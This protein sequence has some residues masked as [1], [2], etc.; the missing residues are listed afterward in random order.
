MA[1]EST[2][3][4]TNLGTLQKP[5]SCGK[6]NWKFGQLTINDKHKTSQTTISGATMIPLSLPPCD[7]WG[8][9]LHCSPSDLA[10][11]SSPARPRG[12]LKMIE[13]SRLHLS[14]IQWISSP[15]LKILDWQIGPG[16]IHQNPLV[17]GPG[18]SQLRQP[19]AKTRSQEPAC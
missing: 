16:K 10:S 7:P 8:S 17:K 1:S 14:M 19:P 13:A 4:K 18:S 2:D 12:R 9:R 3:A 11:S 15:C 5:A 6:E